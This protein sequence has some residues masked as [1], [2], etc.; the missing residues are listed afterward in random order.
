MRTLLP[1]LLLC[2]HA[3]VFL[4][5]QCPITV[6][7]GPDVWLCQVPASAQLNG[8]IQG[9]YI[10]FSWSPTTGMQGAN[11]L[12]PTVTVN[13]PATYVLT[14]RGVNLSNNLIVNGDFEAGNTGFFSNYLYSPTN[15]VPEGTYAVLPNPQTAHAGFA[16]CGDHTSGGG[17][18]M[19]VN[20]AGIPNLNVWCQ[21]VAIQPNTQY[22]FSAWVTSLHPSSP[23]RL[24]FS[25]NGS[26]IGPI[27]TAPSTT[28]TWL[29]FY[30]LWNSGT[31][32]SATICIVN[33]NTTLGGN[34]FA[35]DD[36]VFSPVCTV[37]DTVRVHVV[38]LKAAAAPAI[39]VI[40]CEGSPITLNGNGSSTGPNISYRWE[41]TN[42]N[43]VS[44]DTTLQPVVNSAGAYTLVVTFNNGFVECKRTA[45]VNVIPTNNPLT[46]WIVPPSPLGC[47][48]N[49]VQ[50]RGFT[51]QP[52]FAQYHW[53]S[54]PSGQF[55]SKPDSSTV[56]VSRPGI[57]TL[58]VTN[59][60]T[61]CT[62]TATV[63]VTAAT[64]APIAKAQASISAFFCTS[65]TFSLSGNGSSTGSNYVYTWTALQGGRIISNTD[66]LHARAN[67]PGVYVLQVTNTTNGC[68][69]RDTVKVKDRRKPPIF[70]V[71]TPA[72]FTCAVDTLWLRARI[73]DSGAVRVVWRA[74]DEPLLAGD[75]TFFEIRVL[76]PGRYT[77]T[78]LDTLSSCAAV[79][80]ITVASDT[81]APFASIMPPQRLTCTQPEVVLSGSGSSEGPDYTYRWKT[82]SGGNFT[83]ADTLLNTRA[84]APG[85]Y[86]L[87]VINVKNGC[88]ATD[89][90]R[91]EADENVIV[92]VANAP[93]ILTC[94]RM[95]VT[96]NADGS[97]N[98]PDLQYTWTT[99]DGLV[100]S[101]ANTPTPTVGAPG[102]Y[103]LL[104]INPANGCTASDFVIVQQDTTAPRLSIA[105]PDTLTCSTPVV[106][107]FGQNPTPGHFHYLWTASGGG[108][109]VQ[110]EQTLT[111]L[112]NAAG[113][114]T[115]MATNLHNGCTATAS[116]TVAIDTAAPYVS[117]APVP[118]ITCA[119][120]VRIL[121]G[122]TSSYGPAF[123]FNWTAAEG[124]RFLENT[125]TLTPSIDAAGAYTLTILNHRNG[126]SQSATEKVSIDT[127][128]PPADAG[129][130]GM[131]TCADSAILLVANAG[132]VGTYQYRWQTLDGA[133]ASAPDAAVVK[134]VQAGTYVLHVSN[135]QNGCT[136][137]DTVRIVSNREA[138]QP[139]FFISHPKITCLYSRVLLHVT[140]PAPSWQILWTTSGGNFLTRPDSEA[141]WINGAGEYRVLITDAQNGC[142]AEQT[143]SIALD[144]VQPKVSILPHGFLS[145]TSPAIIL[146]GVVKP[147]TGI[148]FFWARPDIG[149]ILDWK[150]LQ[151]LATEP[152]NYV[153]Q[154]TSKHNG[155]TA[156]AHTT[157]D[158]NQLTPIVSA[159]QDTTL[160]C[161]ISQITLR[162][163]AFGFLPPI[164][165]WTASAGG[166]ILSGANTYQPVVNAPGIYTMKATDPYNGCSNSS[167]VRV[168]LDKDAPTVSIA[169]PDTLTCSR[170][171]VVLQ[172]NGSPSTVHPQWTTIAGGN[173][174]SGSNTFTLLVN[175]P[176]QYLLTVTNPKNGCT[177]TAERVVFQ[178]I[179]K[180]ILEIPAPALLTCTAP[181][182]AVR[183]QP[184]TVAYLYQWQTLGGNIV[185]GT[186]SAQI[187][188]NQ[189][190]TYTVV[191][192]DRRTGCT[193]VYSAEVST[194]QELPQI[195]IAPPPTLT[196]R[197]PQV[198]LVATVD[199]LPPGLLKAQWS[200]TDGQIATGV[201][202]LTPTVAAAGMY[203][204]TVQN[205][206]NG[207]MAS[208]AVQVTQNTVE[209][210]VR[211]ATPPT[212]T[213]VKRQV[214]L[215]ASAS[216]GQGAL[217]FKWS[218]GLVLSGQGT[219]S[220]WVGQPGLYSLTLTDEAN[221]CIAT[222][223]VEVLA[224]TTLPV[225]RI[226]PAP[227]LTCDR[228]TVTLDASASTGQ[229]PLFAQWTTTNGNISSNANTLITSVNAP[230]S[231]LLL[232]T[233]SQN[234]CTASATAIVQEDRT[235]PDVYAGPDQTLYCTQ[236]EV[237]LSGQSNTPGPLRYAWTVVSGGP[238]TG[239]PLIERPT[240][241]KPGIY[242]LTITRLDNGCAASD[243]VQV[244]EI[245]PPEFVPH[246][247][248]PNCYR[249]TG[250]VA[251]TAL[252]GGQP[253]LRYSIDN[254]RTFSTSPLFYGLPPG[255]YTL[256]VSD[257]LGCTSTDF[258]NIVPPL[259]PKI[260]FA[261]LA[262]IDLGDSVRLEPL[263]N[264]PFTSVKAWRWTPKDGLSCD[265][266]STPWASPS[267]STRYH[268]RILDQNGC[269][270]EAHVVVPVSRRRLLY[271]P[272][273]FSPNDD[274]QND[275]FTIF[276][277]R[278]VVSIRSLEIFDRW[279][280]LVFSRQQLKP[281][282]EAAGWDGTFRGQVV[283]P[284]VYVWKAVVVFLDGAEEVFVGDVT[285]HR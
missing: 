128:S 132:K 69:T 130:D 124:G 79:D 199:N 78:V 2:L 215:D 15:L 138:P 33:Q 222:A 58:T 209:P 147:D 12:T 165:E 59:T 224:D 271:A 201:Q 11:T 135:P 176:G 70:S 32:T 73:L 121:D 228:Q 212:I 5:A 115:L 181:V 242:R 55:T 164:V 154:V 216:A 225:V 98:L 229:L 118:P 197:E 49:A 214:M 156:V 54:G 285:V 131:L 263:L 275:R 223:T 161:N 106:V 44:G 101:G 232:L 282:D 238:L 236:P 218:G 76:G 107:L 125:H 226:A 196:C 38:Q 23:A 194:D 221:G 237:T 63:S 123:S 113:L 284:G 8:A 89:S 207:C 252:T 281:N 16:P 93:E 187:T 205:T 6:E 256:L 133:F 137:I 3:C 185:S 68:I 143:F 150:T 254:G 103:T 46:A 22:V 85:T 74:L 75:T 50:L 186:Q 184:D 172:G 139:K 193:S 20:G 168:L 144:T 142:T 111:P 141:V 240:T 206:L 94:Q 110:G 64:E 162:G 200:T 80:T 90:V 119:E 174:L 140:N 198:V 167:Q 1:A 227:L 9:P 112:A 136:S 19:A 183:A 257:A 283:L 258:V 148:T 122:S 88:T 247:E 241:R 18:M 204:L 243:E 279:G 81:M 51:N 36:I 272:N 83:D 116:I 13:G 53:A 65:D 35:L 208:R 248:Q 102:T 42:G 203:S 145:C 114:Y 268:L 57:Y 29:N 41:T 233:N 219:S 159:G 253:P 169:L 82:T 189:P 108:N 255:S 280:N 188:V 26:P 34:D 67:A 178:D 56:W 151:P 259:L 277:N 37:S 191:A 270:A 62:A 109:L 127:L 262:P 163:I 146:P 239:N 95:Q 234:G 48:N 266:C 213:C 126:C 92:A 31:N 210:T 60:M 177:A 246:V 190:G 52:G 120:S 274:G 72:I 173:I 269:T 261:S 45:T 195:S 129:P 251:F 99:V 117:L 276:G 171:E 96:L 250:S 39:S 170:T 202:S 179:T 10:N 217:S 220:P 160:T 47:G 230:G 91:V 25:I 267:Q 4:S 278:A 235:P 264:L 153:L 152:G 7:A 14:G 182:T 149:A 84:N 245:A 211:L 180:P 166:N 104:L 21:T 192:T 30:T 100:L 157:L 244:V 40:P 231:Y 28:C 86:F 77:L 27:F 71:D 66:S 260:S 265:D 155:C 105:T 24:Q 17:N 97:S 43:I 175:M 273:I 87:E 134:V 249:N 158:I 61:G